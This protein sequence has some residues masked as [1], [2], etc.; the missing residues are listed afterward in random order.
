MKIIDTIKNFFHTIATW[1]LT[2]NKDFAKLVR[3]A[4]A[5]ADHEAIEAAN[6]EIHEEGLDSLTQD[7]KDRMANLIVRKNLTINEAMVSICNRRL[8]DSGLPPL[9]EDMEKEVKDGE[10]SPKK[11]L[12]II[13]DMIEERTDENIDLEII[14]KEDLEELKHALGESYNRVVNEIA[15]KYKELESIENAPFERELS[16]ILENELIE[17]L[18]NKG[19]GTETAKESFE[20][21]YNEAITQSDIAKASLESYKMVEESL[22]PI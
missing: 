20:K 2:L 10:I 21:A 18:H 19:Y 4:N 6:K 17:S 12:S 14:D 22:I 9:D 13:N 15:T 16:N 5:K 8:E 1:F 11:A 7:E 3:E